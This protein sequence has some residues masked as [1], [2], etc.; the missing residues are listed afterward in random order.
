MLI[1]LQ[2]VMKVRE[3]RD[4]GGKRDCVLEK[5]NGCVLIEEKKTTTISRT[6]II[7]RKAR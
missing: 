6:T 2:V 3:E 4:S 5:V 7:S 1:V